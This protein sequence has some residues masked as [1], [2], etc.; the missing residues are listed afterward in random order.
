MKKDK[1]VFKVFPEGDVI[2]LFPNE[3]YGGYIL[4]YMHVGQHRYASPEL[5]TDLPDATEEQYAEL[6]KELLN[7]GYIL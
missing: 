2:A 1:V 5:L 6:K 3:S 4:S 7:I